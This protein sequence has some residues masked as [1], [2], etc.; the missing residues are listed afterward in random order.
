MTRANERK[1]KLEEALKNAGS[2]HEDLNAFIAWLTDKEKTLNTLKPVSRV[3]DTVTDQIE[4]HK[5][6]IIFI[7]IAKSI[8]FSMGQVKHTK[9]RW[10]QHIHLFKEC[11]AGE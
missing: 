9:I 2:F 4:Q 7:F 5:V 6:C 8:F 11:T 3:L 1:K 10:R